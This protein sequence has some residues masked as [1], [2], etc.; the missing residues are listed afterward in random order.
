MHQIFLLLKITKLLKIQIMIKKIFLIFV[1]LLSGSNALAADECS[2]SN[3][4][5][6]CLT[7]KYCLYD[8]T[9]NSCMP[10]PTAY[11]NSLVSNNNEQTDCYACATRTIANGTWAPVSPIYYPTTPTTCTYNSENIACTYMNYPVP[12]STETYGY[13]C[14]FMIILD[15]STGSGGSGTIYEV[16]GVKYLSSSGNQIENVA[17]PIKSNSVFTGYYSS[18]SSIA[19]IPDSGILPGNTYFATSTTL[20]AHFSTCSGTG[21][22]GTI[23]SSVSD[24]TC[25]YFITCN[26]GY[27]NTTNYNLATKTTNS[28]LSCTPC[29]AGYYCPG[30]EHQACP[31]GTTSSGGTTATSTAA[32]HMQGGEN[33]TRFCDSNGCFYLPDTATITSNLL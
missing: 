32:C 10:C 29:S 16:S 27:E 8:S 17:K 25:Y 14:A 21:E 18:G 24:N 3:A 13:R 1:L 5:S 28:S 6:G 23:T 22:Q 15:D 20:F 30:G 26:A 19:Q 4:T 11:P 33:G 31:K 9:G 2:I 12:D 7:G